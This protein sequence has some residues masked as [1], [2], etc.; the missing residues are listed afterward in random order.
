MLLPRLLQATPPDNHS[1]TPIELR[2]GTLVATSTTPTGRY[3]RE[4]RYTRT[5]LRASNTGSADTMANDRLLRCGVRAEPLALPAASSIGCLCTHAIE[6]LTARP[7]GARTLSNVHMPQREI[8][9]ISIP[10]AESFTHVY[11]TNRQNIR[12]RSQ[13]AYKHMIHPEGN[14]IKGTFDC[15]STW[16]NV[17]LAS[18]V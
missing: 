13:V 8:T 2:G 6:T 7:Y 11:A 1:A 3:R 17:P 9:K 18:S 14:M 10:S 16:H 12:I 4:D 15:R 5:L